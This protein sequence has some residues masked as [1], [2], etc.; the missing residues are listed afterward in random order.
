MHKKSMNWLQII[1][2]FV[3]PIVGISFFCQSLWAHEK[4]A[5]KVTAADCIELLSGSCLTVR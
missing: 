3:I 5:K 2:F 1:K 4:S